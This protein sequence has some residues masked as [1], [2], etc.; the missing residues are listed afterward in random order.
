MLPLNLLAQEAPPPVQENLSPTELFTQVFTNLWQSFLAG[1]ARFAVGLAVFLVFL[2]VATI[3]KRVARSRLERV[4]SESFAKVVS[5]LITAGIIVFGLIAALPIAFLNLDA[6]AVLG[7][8]SIIALAAGFAF[9]DIASNLMSGLLL[10]IREPFAEGDIIEVNDIR[11]RVV[12]IA[13]RETRIRTLDGHV[14]LVPNKDVYE[15]A[16]DIQTANGGVRTSFVTGVAYGTDLARAR[17]V[18]L[19]TLAGIDGIHAAPAPQAYYIDHGSSSVGLNLRYWTDA[20]PSEVMRVQ[21][22]VAE[23]IHDAFRDADVTIPFDMLTL[24]AGDSFAQVFSGNG[25]S[26]EDRIGVGHEG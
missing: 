11:G 16:I 5:Q 12:G 13:I 9:Q 20:Q 2:V 18:A 23:A 1:L 21:D 19:E 24:D 22:R 17:Q 15:N 3:V 8:L 14:I 4:R 10:V 7:G 26:G 6:T 25:A